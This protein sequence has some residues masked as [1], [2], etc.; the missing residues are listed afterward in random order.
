[1]LENIFNFR[2]IDLGCIA[3]ARAGRFFACAVGAKANHGESDHCGSEIEVEGDLVVWSVLLVYQGWCWY[4]RSE[5]V[6]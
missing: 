6:N 4:L 2:C 5:E 3:C 1:M